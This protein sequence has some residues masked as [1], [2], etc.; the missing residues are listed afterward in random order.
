MCIEYTIT[1][2]RAESD[3]DEARKLRD[4]PLE[5]INERASAG[6]L[7]SGEELSESLP[8]GPAHV[9]PVA[10]F[11]RNFGNSHIILLH[12]AQKPPSIRI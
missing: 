3:W 12:W 6:A 10:V 9:Q 4:E 11:E 2:P 8:E 1:G 5:G 7:R